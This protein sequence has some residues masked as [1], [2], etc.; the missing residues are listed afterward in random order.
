MMKTVKLLLYR[1]RRLPRACRAAEREGSG[2]AIF[3]WQSGSDGSE[4]AQEWHLN[5]ISNRWIPDDT[6]L[7]RHI[8]LAIVYNIWH[9]YQVTGNIGFAEDTFQLKPGGLQKFKLN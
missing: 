7:Q 8:N 5:P 6:N 3:P 2:G 4:Q 9:Y 1:Y